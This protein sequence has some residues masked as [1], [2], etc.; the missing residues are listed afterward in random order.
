MSADAIATAI[1]ELF[2]LRAL[3]LAARATLDPAV[4]AI[5]DEPE[6]MQEALLKTIQ[7]AGENARRI[8]QQLADQAQDLARRLDQ[9]I[10]P[11]AIAESEAE[12]PAGE[13][14]PSEE[15][16]ASDAGTDLHDLACELSGE[17]AYLRNFIE[18]ADDY[19]GDH[20][21]DGKIIA[22]ID[23]AVT[24]VRRA[25]ELAEAVEIGA[26]GKGGAA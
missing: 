24:R 20:C 25:S 1:D 18:L 11:E 21:P 15:A 7:D 5:P 12:K 10:L 9:E 23:A 22:L 3:A 26:C 17:V 2:T 19:A 13:E 8:L 6:E 16:T 14:P 4:D